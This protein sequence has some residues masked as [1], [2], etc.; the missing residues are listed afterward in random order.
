MEPI[1]DHHLD[2]RQALRGNILPFLK[3][4]DTGSERVVIHCW[5][6]NGELF[7]W[8]LPGWLSYEACPR[9]RQ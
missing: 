8:S 7:T 5:G 6:G 9:W 1:A 2:S 3:T 4:A